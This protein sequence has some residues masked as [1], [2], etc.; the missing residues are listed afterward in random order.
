MVFHQEDGLRAAGRRLWGV[1][2]FDGINGLFNPRQIDS[3]RGPVPRLTVH[4]DVAAALFHDPIDRGEP[5]PRAL[6]LRF[7]GEE[8]LEETRL[9]LLVHPA[10]GVA[11]GELNVAASAGIE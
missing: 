8:M 3:E 4:P 9:G 10:H 5:K 1:V 11:D 2:R 7:G 6:A